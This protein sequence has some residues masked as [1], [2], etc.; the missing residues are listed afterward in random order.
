VR[1]HLKRILDIAAVFA[2]PGMVLI[3]QQSKGFKDDD[4]LSVST[5]VGLLKEL[6]M[7]Y[8][9]GLKEL[10]SLPPPFEV[11]YADAAAD[12]GEALPPAQQ[13]ILHRLTD[14]KAQVCALERQLLAN[15][16]GIDWDYSFGPDDNE[17]VITNLELE[18]DGTD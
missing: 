7:A 10:A 16:I 18:E 14:A 12:I 2:S 9:E 6:A 15:G 17:L 13:E 8:G 3:D 1:H 5:S 11:T 4:P